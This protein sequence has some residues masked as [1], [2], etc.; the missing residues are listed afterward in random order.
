M[1]WGTVSFR[2]DLLCRPMAFSF[3]LP[4]PWSAG[5]GPYPVFYLL[6]GYSDDHQTW[7]LQSRLLVYMQSLPMIVVMP[8]GE[9]SF[10]SDALEGD[11]YEQHFL[12]E[13]MG[14]VEGS[15]NAKQGARARCVGG[16]SMGGFGAMMLGLRYPELF[17]SIGA[18]S[19]AFDAAR[20][21]LGWEPI[22]SDLRRIMGPASKTNQHRLNHD[23]F[24]L[25]EKIDRK[26]LPAIYF[27]CGDEDGLLQS[28]RDFEAHLTKLRLPHDYREFPGNH[29]WDYWD[30]HIQDSLAHHRQALGIKRK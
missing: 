21:T 26:K 29:N 4:D 14:I 2:S 28:N 23:P 24:V 3:L 19:S 25:A 7:L 13:V 20:R 27:D 18:H 17:A 8:D 16:L 15:F 9:H 12:K 6:H 30:I 22:K 5:P 11:P 1:S 10:Y